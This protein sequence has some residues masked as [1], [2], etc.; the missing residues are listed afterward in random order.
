MHNVSFLLW[1]VI[2]ATIVI[3][4]AVL[5]FVWSRSRS[6]RMIEQWA[7]ENDLKL[8]S[9]SHCWFKIGTPFWASNKNHTLY[10][11]TVQDEDDHILS[12]FALCGGFFMGLLSDRVEVKWDQESIVKLKND[13]IEKPKND[14]LKR[15]NDW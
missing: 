15:K 14:F 4:F 12:G 5:S 7:V 10:Y 13:E 9:A 6:V 1:W 8:V 2:I 11:I 3:G